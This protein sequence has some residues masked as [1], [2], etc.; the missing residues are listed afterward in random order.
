[1]KNIGLV[2]SGGGGKGA[3]EI[4]VWK[5][6]EEFNMIKNIKAVSGTSVGA[7]NGALFVGN[8]YEDAARVWLDISDDKIK[9]MGK[10]ELFKNIFTEIKDKT[11][12]VSCLASKG[13]VLEALLVGFLSTRNGIY[14]QEG[15]KEI[16]DENLNIDAL[17]SGIPF[18]C[19]ISDISSCDAE[20]IKL[21]DISSSE[22]IKK[23]LLASAAIPVVF[24]K[25]DIDGTTYYDGGIL[26]N[27]P[28]KPLVENENVDFII[29]IMLENDNSYEKQ[30]EEFKDTK[31]WRIIPSGDLGGMIDGTLS[32][33]GAKSRQ[34]IDMGYEDTKK[35]LKDIQ[36]LLISEK[37]YKDSADSFKKQSEGFKQIVLGKN[38]ISK[39]FAGE[40]IY[41]I[42]DNNSKN[43]ILS[44]NN[45]L[46]KNITENASLE[47]LDKYKKDLELAITEGE[48]AILDENIDKLIDEMKDN[49]DKLAKLAV[50]SITAL[51][52]TEGRINNLQ[53]QG[54]FKRMWNGLTGKNQKLSAGISKSQNVAI[55]A[56]TRMIQKL[57]Q[58]SALTMDALISI[59]NKV[60]YMF[61]NINKLQLQ[62]QETLGFI[63]NLRNSVVNALEYIESRIDDNQNRI[64]NLENGQDILFWR[65]G[66]KSKYLEHKNSDKIFYM[67]RDYLA[68]TDGFCQDDEVHYFRSSVLEIVDK[69]ETISRKL[70]VNE[71][72]NDSRKVNYLHSIAE[73]DDEYT[74][75]LVENAKNIASGFNI[76][77][78]INNYDEDDKLPIVDLATE[79]LF[80]LKR[81]IDN[82]KKI[83]DI[84]ELYIEKVLKLEKILKNEDF[85]SKL[86]PYSKEL[87]ENI[88]NFKLKVVILGKNE[89]DKSKLHE[90]LKEYSK[91]IEFL[92]IEDLD[93]YIYDDSVVSFFLVGDIKFIFDRYNNDIIEEL[94]SDG[95]NLL[96]LVTK[97]D[98]KPP[99]EREK[100]IKEL[101]NNFRTLKIINLNLKNSDISYLLG[102]LNKIISQYESILDKM[103]NNNLD[104]IKEKIQKIIKGKIKKRKAL[105]EDISSLESD[106]KKLL[107][108]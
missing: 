33:T 26:D 36:E 100:M 34:L 94:I 80:D 22:K 82:K 70:F 58:R 108:V 17:K 14:S 47:K 1:M 32:F 85:Y 54:F 38:E 24:D 12:L 93:E 49:S 76:E 18:Y 52:S 2:F 53:N 98:S 29:A 10:K 39:L 69:K 68:I 5:A 45:K 73:N 50:E 44:R 97:V 62:Q 51:A 4:G 102:D 66:V 28:I 103:V 61:L 90:Y 7:L 67:V 106:K 16:I 56:N 104:S 89:S 107:G 99:L 101:Q 81:N 74:P 75:L 20:Y 31:I 84:K 60:N 40:K 21:N 71:V 57:S 27:T 3:Y 42:G 63:D 65:G 11:N 43:I 15:L 91:K 96:F 79:L 13:D 46:T 41:E 37:R 78:I 92:I 30:D 88:S 35:I 23:Y 83:I 19:C 86:L 59:N 72:L 6:L 9:K 8:N 87:K 48:K 95:K 64:K 25:V 105:D 55:Y 77:K